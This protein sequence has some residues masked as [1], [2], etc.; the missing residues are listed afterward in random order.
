MRPYQN[1]STEDLKKTRTAYRAIL[2]PRPS[3][4]ERLKMTGC[5]LGLLIGMGGAASLLMDGIN[6][7]N[8]IALLIGGIAVYFW[9]KQEEYTKF[10]ES[11]LDLMDSELS[12][13][14]EF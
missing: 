3:W 2:I 7:V 9:R 11:E 12:G 4:S 10:V 8:G 5:V 14:G 6:G 13:R 1:I